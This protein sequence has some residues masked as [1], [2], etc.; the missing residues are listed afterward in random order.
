MSSD[1]FPRDS[2][3]I[4]DSASEPEDD[5]MT[6]DSPEPP[7]PGAANM[8]PSLPSQESHITESTIPDFEDQDSQ[9][10]QYPSSSDGQ[11]AMPRRFTGLN[12]PIAPDDFDTL[13]HRAALARHGI[14]GGTPTPNS[15]FVADEDR[16]D[17]ASSRASSVAES[18]VDGAASN[19]QEP[20]H[21]PEY[22]FRTSCNHDLLSADK[23]PA[24]PGHA[25][26]KLLDEMG[27]KAVADQIIV[28]ETAVK[29]WKGSKEIE[30]TTQSLLLGCL[31]AI[32]RPTLQALIRGDL[33]YQVIHNEEINKRAKTMRDQAPKQV[34]AIYYIALAD[35]CGLSPSTNLL[36]IVHDVLLHYLERTDDQDDRWYEIF[37]EI[38]TYKHGPHANRDRFYRRYLMFQKPEGGGEIFKESRVVGYRL[39]LG[40]LRKLLCSIPSSERAKP[41]PF[42]LRDVGYSHEPSKRYI[43]HRD[44]RATSNKLMNLLDATINVMAARHGILRNQRSPYSTMFVILSFIFAERLA[45]VSEIGPSRLSSSYSEFSGVG[46]N[47][48]AAGRSVPMPKPM[49]DDEDWLRVWRWNVL[50]SRIFQ[51]NQRA[52]KQWMENKK[53]ALAAALAEQKHAI[54]EQEIELLTANE[55]KRHREAFELMKQSRGPALGALLSFSRALADPAGL[56]A[57]TAPR[58][59]TR[60][61]PVPEVALAPETGPIL[62]PHQVFGQRVA[63]P[64]GPATLSV[65]PATVPDDGWEDVPED[66]ADDGADDGAEEGAEGSAADSEDSDADNDAPAPPVKR[67]RGRPKGSRN[68]TRGGRGSRG[69]RGRGSRGSRAGRGSRGSRGS[70]RASGHRNR[71]SDSDDDVE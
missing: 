58:I 70:R 32:H 47:G 43:H 60:A 28:D 59:A 49:P 36:M 5:I 16:E 64:A 71:D 13:S 39:F 52:D 66:G 23:A 37:E 2:R 6:D 35:E 19:D 4:P 8:P 3:V 21:I 44:H 53:Q 20:N 61:E 25:Y 12:L 7:V 26:E 34:A 42:P 38:D 10:Q 54:E 1:S 27:L 65:G 68:K 41:F 67:G 48:M 9:N 50:H 45:P 62:P 22:V 11:P 46:L 56:N 40:N 14:L 15:S 55:K 29:Y 69:P 18:F 30:K 24:L 51:D 63:V 17:E 57:L 33:S 31:T